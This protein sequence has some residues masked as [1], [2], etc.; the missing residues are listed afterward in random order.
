[1]PTLIT[2]KITPA[3]TGYLA[4]YTGGYIRGLFLSLVKNIDPALA[5]ILHETRMIKPYAIKPLRPINEKMRIDRGGWRI[6]KNM[7]LIFDISLI[8]DELKEILFKQFLTLNRVKI[9]NLE[10]KIEEIEVKFERFEQMF[11]AEKSPQVEII[12]A[13]PTCFKDPI[14][15]Y[16]LYPRPDK[17]FYNLLKIWNTYAPESVRI[18]K[19]DLDKELSMIDIHEYQIVTREVFIDENIKILGFKGSIRLDIKNFEDTK[20]V[21]PLLALSKYSN[22]GYGRTYGLGSVMIT[23]KTEQ[24]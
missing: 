4:P 22:V 6:H 17:I 16:Y 2:Y 13:T 7:K 14:T 10:F 1:M 20:A 5:E 9:G 12:F 15:R 24:N 23:K 8:D 11:Q 18:E 3:S 19:N 21:F